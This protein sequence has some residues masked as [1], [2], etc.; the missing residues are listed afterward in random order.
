[1]TRLAIKHINDTGGVLGRALE[2]ILVDNHSPPIESAE[3]A[4]KLG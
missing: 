3:A 1:M 4:H 2:L